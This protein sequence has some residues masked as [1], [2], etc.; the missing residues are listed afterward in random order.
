MAARGHNS[1]VDAPS[2][3]ADVT[4]HAPPIG[5]K[6]LVSPRGVANRATGVAVIASSARRPVAFS[7]RHLGTLQL[8]RE[9]FP[10]GQDHRQI[11][12]FVPTGLRHRDF[13]GCTAQANSSCFCRSVRRFPLMSNSLPCLSISCKGLPFPTTNSVKQT[14]ARK[15]RYAPAF[16]DRFGVALSE[17]AAGDTLSNLTVRFAGAFG[18]AESPGKERSPVEPVVE[19][20]IMSRTHSPHRVHDAARPMKRAQALSDGA[21]TIGPVPDLERHLPSDWWRTLF[22][23]IYLKT[24]GDVVE[25]QVN[26]QREVDVLVRVAGLEPNDRILDLCCGQGRHLLELA[27]RGF[28]HLTGV[29][30][31]RYLI[32]LARRRAKSAGL[33]VAFHEGDAR[34]FRAPPESFHCV[35]ILGNSF[36]YFDRQED[37]CAVLETVKRVLR[38]GGT[39]V[40]DVVDG[41]WL[42]VHFDA[43]SWEW[44]DQN[45][46]VCRERALSA[47]GTRLISRE[48]VVHCERG[49]II[50]QFYAERLYSR[51]QIVELLK[52]VGFESIRDHGSLLAESDRGQDLGMM[53]HRMLITARAPARVGRPARRGPPFPE[54]TVLLGDPRLPDPVK[55]GGRFNPEDFD[56]IER[57]KRALAELSEFRF[58]YLDNHASMLAELRADPPQFVFNLCDEGF[59]NDPFKELHV[60][61]LLEMLHVP[62]SGAR[63]ACLGLCYNKSFVRA[64]AKSLDIPTPLETYFDPDDQSA[65]LPS[66]FPALVKP[67][68]GDSSLGIT[69]DAVVHTPEQLIQYLDKLRHQLPGRPLLIQEFLPGRE[70]SVGIVGNPGLGYHVLPVL[71]VDYSGL[72]EGLP[73]ILGY[74]SKWEPDSPYWTQIK[75][76]EADLHEDAQRKLIDYSILL[77]ERLECRD[78]AR[79]DYRADAAGKI[80]LLEVNPNPGWCW[81]GKLNYMAGFA[82][83]RYADLLR[84][85]LLAAQE[86][87]APG[88]P[89]ESVPIGQEAAMADLAPAC[90]P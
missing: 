61:A 2:K 58:R 1:A 28:R 7:H 18:M 85:I 14:M 41:E 37:D 86:R 22:N 9:L 55:R 4:A 76:H 20:P 31:S 51:G 59:D 30:R 38:P 77:F 84:M 74:E 8:E 44:I 83:L 80:K 26:T 87:G 69:Q 50:D 15:C 52:R 35:T 19:V 10:V 34:K 3:R 72:D 5:V 25:N 27:R 11:G 68:Y 12:A 46:L 42:R 33:T 32:R 6:E 67:N 48:V 65:T 49:V 43:R 40:L 64:I 39:L 16:R 88:R 23:S 17:N 21:R 53:A 56:T 89:A 75:Y 73:H 29:D 57:L 66:V 79:F 71:E 78:Y 45:H 63:P 70:F 13:P 24:D 82:G 60:P 54:V 62:Y 81:D 36:G 47:D 90:R